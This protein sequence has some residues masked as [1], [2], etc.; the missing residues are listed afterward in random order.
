MGGPLLRIIM[1]FVF[2]LD[3]D[4]L[5]AVVGP[6]RKRIPDREV[7]CPEDGDGRLLKSFVIPI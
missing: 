3:R 2:F 5:P 7:A 4:F 1:G 6:I